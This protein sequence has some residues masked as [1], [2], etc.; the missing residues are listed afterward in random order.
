MYSLFII[1]ISVR[2]DEKF[3]FGQKPSIY[4]AVGVKRE[5]FRLLLNQFSFPLISVLS[6]SYITPI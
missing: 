3:D 5:R 2:D 1:S 4:V 6:A